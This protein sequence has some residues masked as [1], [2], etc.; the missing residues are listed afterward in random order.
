MRLSGFDNLSLI[1]TDI[2]LSIELKCRDIF[3]VSKICECAFRDSIDEYGLIY[4]S[5]CT[6]IIVIEMLLQGNYTYVLYSQLK[7]DFFMESDIKR[8]FS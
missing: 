4:Q 5:V 1:K 8:P 2:N 6:S 3:I 7:L